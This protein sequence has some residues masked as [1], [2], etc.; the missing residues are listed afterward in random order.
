MQSPR[1]PLLRTEKFTW[2]NAETF[3]GKAQIVNFGDRTIRNGR[4][5]WTLSYP[6]GRVYRKGSFRATDIPVGPITELGELSIPLS[7]IR[8]AV[9]MTLRFALTGTDVA[10]EWS[11]WVYPEQLPEPSLDNVVV[12]REWNETVRDQLLNGATVFL[13]AD[14]ERID[15]DVPPG[16]SGIS[17]NAVWSGTPPNLLGILCDPEHPALREFPTEFHSNWQWFDLVRYSRPMLLDHTPALFRPVVQ[18]IPDWNNNRKIGLILEARVGKG[19]LLMTS[20]D[21]EGIREKSPVAR[22][23]LYSLE[24]YVAG[25]GFNPEATLAPDMIDKL[26]KTE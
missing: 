12:A 11:V 13:M 17:W 25:D 14:P 16:F 6:D 19:K 9:K 23:M 15:S 4:V 1:K 24:R 21:L 8:E 3:T 10:N 5:A 26:F 20:I 7:G 2:T 22:Q 18:M